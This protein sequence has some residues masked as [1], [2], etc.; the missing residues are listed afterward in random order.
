MSVF[1]LCVV[2]CL[3]FQLNVWPFLIGVLPV[4]YQKFSCYILY[5]IC[6]NCYSKCNSMYGHSTQIY[7]SYTYLAKRGHS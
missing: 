3:Q 2:Y 4:T 7:S 1:V 6:S 5:S